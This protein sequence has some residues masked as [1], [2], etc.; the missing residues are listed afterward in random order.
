MEGE[1]IRCPRVTLRP[2]V[3]AFVLATIAL[4]TTSARSQTFPTTWRGVT[5]SGVALAD[6][7]DG[8]TSGRD[9]VGDA[10]NPAAY[11][12]SDAEFLYLRL[13]VNTTAMSGTSYTPFVW[14]CLLETDEDLTSY[15]NFVFVDGISSPDA[16]RVKWNQVKSILDSTTEPAETLS[17]TYAIETHARVVAAT[18]ALGGDPDFFV[19]FVAAW[20]VMNAVKPNQTLRL[21]CGSGTSA[22]TLNG[23]LAGTSSST[24]LTALWSDALVCGALGCAPPLPPDAGADSAADA[25]PD[26]LAPDTSSA[27]TGAV[28]DT[29]SSAADT[30]SDPADSSAPDSGVDSRGATPDTATTDTAVADSAPADTAATFD[31]TTGGK[32]TV[33]GTFQGCS[34]PSECS[35]GFC[36]DGVCC[37]SAC[38]GSCNSCALP[39]SPGRCATVPAGLDP[40][41]ACGGGQTCVA[42]CG[43]SGACITSGA[44]AQCARAQ[45]T[46]PTTGVGPAFCPAQGSS[47]PTAA[48][49][50]FDC[51]PFACEPVF[52]AC[53]STCASSSDCAPSFNCDVDLGRCKPIP[54]AEDDGGCALS[55]GAA[56]GASM[57][58]AAIAG[59]LMLVA[60]RASRRTKRR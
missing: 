52:G 59:A 21:V 16:V 43:P 15:E 5:K 32:P 18:S 24:T 10:A 47:C 28:S 54:A 41:G 8:T 50:A 3:H 42:T 13:R 36:V 38:E 58:A 22:S 33:E 14:G 23:D 35:S 6:V 31:A 11:V 4:A 57:G 7:V 51:S 26:T 39:W 34:A 20:T 48:Q 45:C 37:D 2:L 12:W 49:Q 9:V 17:A 55:P 40:R 46:G 44:G 29:G 27:D 53:R 19:D 60:A 1:V 30:S 56:R 25:P